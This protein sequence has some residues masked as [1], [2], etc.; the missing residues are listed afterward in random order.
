MT[1][2]LESAPFP[3]HSK[4]GVTQRVHWISSLM[5]GMNLIV[6][7]GKKQGYVKQKVC[8]GYHGLM[9]SSPCGYCCNIGWPVVIT[10]DINTPLGFI[11]HLYAAMHLKEGAL[12]FLGVVCSTWTTINRRWAVGD[13]LGHVLRVKQ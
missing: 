5:N 3:V 13:S 2:L 9:C 8:M 4:P 11:R 1:S 10:K 12:A 7:Y 6:I